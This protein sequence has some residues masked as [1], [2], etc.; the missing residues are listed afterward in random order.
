MWRAI[1]YSLREARLDIQ[2]LPFRDVPDTSRLFVDFLSNV[3]KARSFYPTSTSSL[4]QLAHQA[5]A[6]EIPPDRRERISDIVD[7][8]NRQWNTGAETLA[9]IQKLRSGARAVVTGQQVG[10][11]LGPAYTLYKAI[12]VIR[13]AREFNARGVEAVP[14]FWLASEDHDLAEVNHTFVADGNG[15]LRRLETSS[16]GQD[17]SPVGKI[18][19]QQDVS[20]LLDQLQEVLGDSQV[21]DLVRDSYQPGQTLAGAFAK[22]LTR[23][24]SKYGLI[25]LEPSEPELHE[26]GAPLLT[27]AAEQSDALTRALLERNQELESAGYHAQ[28]KVTQS[29]TLLFSLKDGARLPVRRRNSHFSVNGE[30]WTAEEFPK[31]VKSNP[32][33]FT[34]NVLLRPALQDYLLPTIVYVGGPAETAYFAQVHVVYEQLLGRATPVWP[35]FSTTLIEARLASWMRKYG[36]RLRDVLQ[37]HD[38]FLATL[39]RRVIPADIKEDFDRSREQLERLLTPLLHSLSKLDPTIAA[40]GDTAAHKMRYQLEQLESRA[41]RAHLQREQVLERHATLL[42]TMLFPGKELQ[43]RQIGAVYFLSKFGTELIDQLVD[44]YRVDCPDHQVI[45]FD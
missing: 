41:S 5:R 19:L 8:Q 31:W 11:F 12:T 4:D 34:P 43:E 20:S 14:I 2:C 35:R 44:A 42:S 16:H 21:L 10:L 22:L 17:G 38:E 9:N 6:I 27:A 25:L 26:L 29:S 18:V 15:V 3:P 33:L 28:V 40:A 39:A 7:K 1:E 23:I 45:S 30:Q 36:L 24:F 13:L 32:R 37:P